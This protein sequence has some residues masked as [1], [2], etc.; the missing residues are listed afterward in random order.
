MSL[1]N[2]MNIGKTALF[3]NQAALNVTGHN[4]SNV[5]TPGYTRQEV[6]LEVA[7]PAANSAGYL[8]GA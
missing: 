8:G 5:N 7:T 3:A 1:L 4:I 2:I 6:I